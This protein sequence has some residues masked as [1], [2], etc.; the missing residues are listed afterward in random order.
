MLCRHYSGTSKKLL[1]AIP[2]EDVSDTGVVG[3]LASP[4][5]PHPHVTSRP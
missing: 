3:T 4:V 1:T 5:L 2:F